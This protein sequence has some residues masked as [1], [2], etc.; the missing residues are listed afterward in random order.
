MDTDFTWVE[1]EGFKDLLHVEMYA[2]VKFYSTTLLG[3]TAF[4]SK[5][6]ITSWK[7]GA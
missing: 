1:D 7:N 2:L 5:T 3:N 4:P 6:Y